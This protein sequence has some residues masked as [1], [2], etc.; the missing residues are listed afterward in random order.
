[1]SRQLL[2]KESMRGKMGITYLVT[3]CIENGICLMK[4]QLLYT[5][6]LENNETK[7]KMKNTMLEPIWPNKSCP[8]GG[9]LVFLALLQLS[10]TF[11]ESFGIVFRIVLWAKPQNQHLYFIITP[12]FGP[13]RILLSL[14]P[15]L[16]YQTWLKLFPKIYSVIG[17]LN[18]FIHLFIHSMIMAECLQWVKYP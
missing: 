2:R 5:V 4:V 14:I 3:C 16:I 9:S 18:F 11:S 12:L 17:Q 6:W 10:K 1:M 8:T 13:K 15:Q 7:K